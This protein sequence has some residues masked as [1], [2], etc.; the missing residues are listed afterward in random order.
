VFIVAILAP[1]STLSEGTII[2]GNVDGG[3]RAAT[4]NTHA[5]TGLITA[6]D[7]L[8]VTGGG[9][10]CV[11]DGLRPSALLQN[12][13]AYWPLEEGSGNARD[14]V[15]NNDLTRNGGVTRIAG[16]IGNA[17]SLAASSSQNFSIAD[18]ADLS[19]GAVSYSFSCW[20]KIDDFGAPYAVFAKES[21]AGTIEYMLF[22]NP[23]VGFTFRIGNGGAITGSASSASISTGRWYFV[24]CY[25]DNTNGVVGI[26]LNGSPF[27]TA[28]ATAPGDSSVSFSIGSRVNTDLFLN[29]KV[30][31]VRFWKSYVLSQ[32][33]VTALYNSGRG[34]RF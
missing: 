9:A 11:S 29:G 24:A 4:I 17:A 25:Y 20:A 6:R 12:L 28:A 2:E 23:G 26:S 33:D 27:T 30:D 7:H 13:V 18:N 14:R 15:G 21:G 34:M 5:H 32:A 16:I 19:T 22:S 10:T 8:S 1:P 3:G 31:E